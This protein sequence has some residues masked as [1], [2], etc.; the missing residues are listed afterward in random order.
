MSWSI[1]SGT[2]LGSLATATFN[3]PRVVHTDGV[4]AS[5]HGADAARMAYR[6]DPGQTPMPRALGVLISLS[7]SAVW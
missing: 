4:Q 3:S 2:E 1:I 7:V 5:L 6:V